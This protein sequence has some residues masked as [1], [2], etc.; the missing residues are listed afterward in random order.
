MRRNQELASKFV[1]GNLTLGQAYRA[2]TH[3]LDY[4][5]EIDAYLVASRPIL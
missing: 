3:Y 2:M 5:A 1:I 4:Q